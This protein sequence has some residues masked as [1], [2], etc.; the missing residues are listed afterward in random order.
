[1]GFGTAAMG[2]APAS[3]FWLALAGMLFAG[4]MNPIA[5]GPLIALLQ[6]SVAPD[7]QG[8]VLSLVQSGAAAMM[9]LSLLVAG[10]V[11]DALGVR[12]WYLIGGAACTL[13]GLLAF[14]VPA[15]MHVEQ[16]DPRR[17]VGWKPGPEEVSAIA[18]LASEGRQ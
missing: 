10:P 15:I 13:I 17:Q 9:P 1:M 5:N 7:M 14:G 6:S 3:F 11:A 4:F 12:V 18:A 2:L 8:R 16:N